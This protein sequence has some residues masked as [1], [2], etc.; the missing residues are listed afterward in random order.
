MR[1]PQCEI[2]LG[3]DKVRELETGHEANRLHSVVPGAH[4]GGTEVAQLLDGRQAVQPA[5]PH[6]HRVDGATADQGHQRV[7]RLLD[8]Q[9]L[10]DDGTVWMD[11][12]APP[13]MSWDRSPAKAPRGLLYHRYELA[14]DGTI[15]DATIVPPTSQ[16]QPSIEADLRAFVQKRLELP[17]DELIRQCEQAIRN[18]DPCIS[19]A[20]HF[21]D[22]TM[23]VR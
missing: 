21:L 19:C 14:E 10:P 18:Y 23:D 15:L 20:T 16:N 6:V 22:L 4:Q 3:L 2:L 1:R 5:D 17:R 11:Q 13:R 7:A 9:P 8:A 12:T